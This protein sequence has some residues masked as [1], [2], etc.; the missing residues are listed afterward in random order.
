MRYPFEYGPVKNTTPGNGTNVKYGHV[1]NN[2]PSA[3]VL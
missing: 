1:K 3:A 2:R